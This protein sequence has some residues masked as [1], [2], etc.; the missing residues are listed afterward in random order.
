MFKNCKYFLTLKFILMLIII[1]IF[2]IDKI[3][4]SLK[5]L[6]MK[7]IVS[8]SHFNHKA[9]EVVDYQ[10][11]LDVDDVLVFDYRKFYD[12]IKQLYPRAKFIT[13]KNTVE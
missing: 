5:L 4:Y 12:V 1:L 10:N 3:N 8:A 13:F 2:A 6:I 7:I 11:E 9:D